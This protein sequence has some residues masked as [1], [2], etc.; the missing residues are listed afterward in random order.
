MQLIEELCVCVCVCVC[1]LLAD[2]KLLA[3]YERSLSQRQNSILI[4]CQRIPQ[5][6]LFILLVIILTSDASANFF[7]V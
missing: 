1:E 5:P 6:L 4:P 2:A 7:V 3:Q